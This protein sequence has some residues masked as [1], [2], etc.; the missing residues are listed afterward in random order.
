MKSQ[1]SEALQDWISILWRPSSIF[2]KIAPSLP[3]AWRWKWALVFIIVIEIISQIAMF[4]KPAIF[5]QAKSAHLQASEAKMTQQG[6][7]PELKRQALD[8]MENK[9]QPFFFIFIN[10]TRAIMETAARLVM[11]TGAFWILLRAVFD[12]FPSL[13]PTLEVAGLSMMPLFLEL[14]VKLIL[15][16]TTGQLDASPS[17]ALFL[18]IPDPLNIVNI[19]LTLLNPFYFWSCLLLA[20]ASIQIWKTRPKST[21][22]WVFAGWMILWFGFAFLQKI[23][24]LRGA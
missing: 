20:L 17:L 22:F 16:F 3:N 8:D 24:S 11:V 23:I 13:N 21:F 10:S 12:K 1:S 7:E 4:S 15:V 6:I 5:Q 19:A 2:Q 9:I 14:C 18:S